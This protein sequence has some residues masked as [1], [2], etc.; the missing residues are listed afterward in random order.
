L[1]VFT[2]SA[3]SGDIAPS[4]EVSAWRWAAVED[5]LETTP[6]LRDVLRLIPALA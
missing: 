3:W 5:A 6:G 2:T 1:K 4:D